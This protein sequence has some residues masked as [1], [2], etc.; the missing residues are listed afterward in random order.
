MVIVAFKMELPETA[1]FRIAIQ[2]GNDM[3]RSLV[4]GLLLVALAAAARAETYYVATDGKPENDGS[5]EKPWPSAEFALQ[6]VG[7][8][9]TIVVRPGFY[10]GP[11]EVARAYAG[12]ATGPMATCRRRTRPP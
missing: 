7:G 1:T 10:R 6:K 5:C 11:L 2:G 4:I 9:H 3:S 12:T 8:G